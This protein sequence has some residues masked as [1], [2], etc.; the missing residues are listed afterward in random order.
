MIYAG[1]VRE[2][3]QQ[4]RVARA[5]L[6]GGVARVRRRV[7]EALGHL[8]AGGVAPPPHPG[9]QIPR[10]RLRRPLEQGVLPGGGRRRLRRSAVV[11]LSG[12]VQGAG[13]LGQEQG[14]PGR[15]HRH[16]RRSAAIPAIIIRVIYK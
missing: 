11:V 9:L 12:I 6:P 2:L 16:G 7:H 4:R 14:Q 5:G 3:R 15:H 10:C 1:R 8:R 13:R